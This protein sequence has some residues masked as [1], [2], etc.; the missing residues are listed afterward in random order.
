MPLPQHLLPPPDRQ[1][2]APY[3]FVPLPETVKVVAKVV[4]EGE[5]D[6]ARPV[7]Q[8]LPGL[9]A[10]APQGFPHSGWI[11]VEI[12]AMSPLF[13]RGPM[14]AQDVPNKGDK[15]VK[16]RPDFFY[17]DS[18]TKQ[19]VIPGSS[20]RGM[21]R[22]VIEVASASKVSRVTDNRLFSRSFDGS[23]MAVAYALRMKQQ[24]EGR[25]ALRCGFLRVANGEYE[26]V[27]VKGYRVPLENIGRE[28]EIYDGR[29]PNRTPHW[30]ANGRYRQYAPVRFTEDGKKV[31]ALSADPQ[32]KG[33]DGV[34]V[35]SGAMQG[36]KHDW[37][38]DR[39]E[40]H[41]VYTW[42]VEEALVERFN[43]DDQVTQ[44][45]QKA[46][47][48][49]KPEDK[50]RPKKGY[51]IDLTKKPRPAGLPGEPVFFLVED[52]K[53]AFFGRARYFRLPYKTSPFDLVPDR[54]KDPAEI[55]Y[56]EALFGFVRQT[57]ER[58]QLSDGGI[59]P[60]GEAIARAGRVTVSDGEC[61]TG[62]NVF[63]ET[64]TPRIL[65]TPN[66]TSFQLYLTQTHHD[67][68]AL[69]NFDSD[70]QHV[71]LRG[72]KRYWPQ[73][74][75][76]EADL[77]ET[78]TVPE[79]S[80]QHTEV[81]PVKPGTHFGFRVHFTNLSD[82]ELGALLWA[83][84]LPGDGDHAG[85]DRVTHVHQ[86]GMGKPLGMGAVAVKKA[87]VTVVEAKVRYGS[88][89]AAG[90][91]TLEPKQ[92]AKCLSAFEADVPDAG[93]RRKLLLAMMRW[94]GLRPDPN[95]GIL[96]RDRPNTRYMEIE[97]LGGDRKENEYK[98]RRVLPPVE[99]FYPD[100]G[101][102]PRAENGK[103]QDILANEAK[104]KQ[105]DGPRK[106]PGGG[107]G[108]RH[109][110]YRSDDGRTAFQ[111]QEDERRAAERKAQQE[112]LS[113]VPVF[114]EGLENDTLVRARVVRVGPV[115][116]QLSAAGFPER[117]V[118]KGNDAGLKVGDWVV[119][120]MQGV[121]ASGTGGEARYIRR[122][123]GPGQMPV[124]AAAPAASAPTV[125]APTGGSDSTER[126]LQAI[127]TNTGKIKGVNVRVQLKEDSGR[128]TNYNA[129]L[130]EAQA[131]D[132]RRVRFDRIERDGGF[133]AENVKPVGS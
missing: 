131:L 124:G 20:L 132:G 71:T 88:L 41:T 49:N 86:L 112:R 58:E 19:P 79:G 24:D 121:G 89:A 126:G 50:A 31:V 39:P 36:K 18:T 28:D 100:L 22:S 120:Q 64:F 43:D 80:K 72:T 40:E 99:A 21:L 104:L 12:E 76:N 46:F 11:D 107:R 34:L 2:S 85:K 37:V 95:G 94:P 68:K 102:V 25:D 123:D 87:V 91:E 35:L 63:M 70:P 129:P 5:G 14:R 82:R 53:V 61:R 116:A 114:V 65:S 54:L 6:E 97:R 106:A 57:W 45:Q 111:R 48:E 30:N 119:V 13:I 118:L 92:E 81:K 44:W 42:P 109:G 66:P 108:D 60:Q 55:D 117:P 10:V 4:M 127:A 62:G 8:G 130:A 23:S 17:T 75:R 69:R 128:T 93:K 56:A 73:G 113:T 51:L 59:T 78:K 38:F 74:A 27:E 110:G 105:L 15:K 33:R 83:L 90:T 9:D 133:G 26:I 125:S 7:V 77:R 96:L 52:G 122:S 98:R 47:P 29:G 115:R 101:S 1:A 32:G 84:R 16:D 67:E 103:P 3:N